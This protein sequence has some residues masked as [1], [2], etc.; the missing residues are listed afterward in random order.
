[1]EIHD[2]DGIRTTVFF[3]GCPLKCLWCHNPESISFSKQ[4]AFFEDKCI[5][6]VACYNVCKN[7]AINV[8]Q[9]KIAIDYNNCKNC[10]SCVDVC[11]TCARVAFGVEY[12]VETLVQ[13]LLVDKEYFIAS[14]GGVT[15][16]GGECL[17]QSEFAISL[18][19][20][21]YELGISVDID[22]CG[23]VKRQVLEDI[24]PFVD[25]FLYDVKAIDK[26]LHQKLTGKSNDIILDNLT[27]LINSGKKVEIRYPLV[28]TLN[29]S[30]IKKIG[31][32]LSSFKNPPKIKVLQYHSFSQ[33][34]YTALNMK[35]QMTNEKTTPKDVA[36]AVE[37]LKSYNL[38]AINGIIDD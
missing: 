35:S 9:N 37:I 1:M 12:D 2:G 22:T 3:K 20:R 21:L 6:C 24:C 27:W 5:G 16:S 32:F 23:Y 31:E 34:R 15:L 18:A 7:N 36:Y 30:Q 4:L 14:N 26:A 19:K 38:D 33:S 25:T 28:Q 17:A 13:T 11:P 10:F 8:N 29:D